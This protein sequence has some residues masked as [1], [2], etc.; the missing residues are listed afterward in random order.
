MLQ[1]GLDRPDVLDD[2][3]TPA[4]DIYPGAVTNAV[5][6]A[7][8]IQHVAAWTGIRNR[9]VRLLVRDYDQAV[10]LFLDLP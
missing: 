8:H 1:Y 5:L 9:I 2:R 6:V 7:G 4:T 10:I 3:I